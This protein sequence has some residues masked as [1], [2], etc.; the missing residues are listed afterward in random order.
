MGKEPPGKDWTHRPAGG[1]VVGQARGRGTT[2][3][4]MPRA[5]TPHRENGSGRA[6]GVSLPRPWRGRFP[7]SAAPRGCGAPGPSIS[8]SARRASLRGSWPLTSRRTRSERWG[9]R[10]ARTRVGTRTASA[11]RLGHPRLGAAVVAGGDVADGGQVGVPRLADGIRVSGLG[12]RPTPE[13]PD[14]Q[15]PVV[16]LHDQFRA[17]CKSIRTPVPTESG[18]RRFSGGPVTSLGSKSGPLRE[19][20]KNIAVSPRPAGE[21]V[22]P[23]LPCRSRRNPRREK[24]AGDRG[25]EGPEGRLT[26]VLNLKCLVTNLP[27]PSRFPSRAFRRSIGRDLTWYLQPQRPG[28]KLSKSCLRPPPCPRGFP[29]GEGRTFSRR[30]GPASPGRTAKGRGLI[31]D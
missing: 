11:A 19:S 4:R 20:A 8:A 13:Q 25:P 26:E 5:K 14:A 30:T 6:A 7:G 16:F 24:L 17:V 22:L 18:G 2:A 12:D 21:R 15:T 3:V 10:W 23:A 1:G 9:R 29:G 28:A 31:T 27:A